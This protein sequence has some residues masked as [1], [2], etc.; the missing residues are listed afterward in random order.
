MAQVNGFLYNLAQVFG[1]PV[2]FVIQKN[3]VLVSK[4]KVTLSVNIL[5]CN[6]LAVNHSMHKWISYNFAQ[7]LHIRLISKV[8]D[9]QTKKPH[10]YGCLH[11]GICHCR[12]AALFYT[13]LNFVMKTFCTIPMSTY[14]YICDLLPSI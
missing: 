1:I 8:Y 5:A 10:R 11:K 9:L 6:R 3:H 4:M 2:Q 14:H 12:V 7:L 13:V